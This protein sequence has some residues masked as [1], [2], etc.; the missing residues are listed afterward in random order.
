[1]EKHLL[2]A[3]G[4]IGNSGTGRAGDCA[5]SASTSEQRAKSAVRH[6]RKM[7]GLLQRNWTEGGRHHWE[8]RKRSHKSKWKFPHTWPKGLSKN[9][10][11]FS[12][13]P[14]AWREVLAPPPSAG[15]L[16]LPT[17]ASYGA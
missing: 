6:R 10:V 4:I 12:Q 2:E 13:K 7:E 9:R 8:G 5:G 14:P 3:H 17:S 16:P 1:M 15:K 11:L